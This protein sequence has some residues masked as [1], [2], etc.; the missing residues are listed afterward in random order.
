MP[1]YSV[2]V[3]VFNSSQSLKELYRQLSDTFAG[4]GKSYEVIFV[5]DASNDNA[6][7]YCCGNQ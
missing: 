2:I 4:I 1:D 6:M 5:D 7:R 3:P